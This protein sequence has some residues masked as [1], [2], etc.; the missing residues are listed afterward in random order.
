MT[1]VNRSL[2]VGVLV[3]MVSFEGVEAKNAADTETRALT[4]E[5]IYSPDKE[6]RLDFSGSVPSIRWI[7]DES[8]VERRGPKDDDE[9]D[10]VLVKVDAESGRAEPFFDHAKMVEQLA[11]LPG[12]DED[13]AKK[14]AYG[15]L[16]LDENNRRAL[17]NQAHDLFLYD[18]ET[19]E[20]RRLTFD[21]KEEVGEEF[22]PDG[23]FVSFI[24]DYNLHLLDLESGRERALTDGG[25]PDLFFGRLDWVYQEEVYGRGNFKG[26]WWSPDSGHLA[27]FK[28]DESKVREFTVVDHLPT[29]LTTEV[30]NYPKAGS[31]NPEV[32]LGVVSALGGDT[33]WLD[34][35]KYESIQHL[36]V[37]VGWTPDS[38]KVIF[39]VQ[40][41]EQEWLELLSASPATG[42]STKILREESP[43]FVNAL[44]MPEWLDDGG[45]LWRSERTGF[46][47]VYRYDTDYQLV[48]AVTEGEWEVRSLHGVDEDAGLVFVTAMEES[49]IAPHVYQVGLDGKGLKRLSKQS[50]S[51]SAS[52]SKKQT[53]F[54]DRW[55]N[56]TTPTQAR[57]YRRNGKQVRVVDENKVEALDLFEWGPVERHQ[58]KTR[59][60]FVME[61]MLMK[62][63]DFDPSK[64]YPVL[65]YNYGG[66]HAPVVRDAWGGQ[67]YAWH[68]MLAQKGYLIWMC[69]NR[70]ASG[71]GIKPTW[72]AFHRMGQPELADIEDGLRW[73]MEK[74]WVDGGR[75]GIWGW[76]YGGFMASYALTHSKMF[77]AGIAGAPVT[78]WHLY[79]SIYTER[80][81]GTPQ[82]NPEGYDATSV[83]KAAKDL[84]GELL[85]VHGTIDDNVHFQNTVQLV[86]ELQKAGKA[87]ELMIYPK[88][89]HG[90]RD[91][92]Q[93]FHLQR[94]MTDFLLRKL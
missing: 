19:E 13:T 59:D 61:A 60:G 18:L 82:N 92:D 23:R 41:R 28:L 54:Y 88:S 15:S 36:I 80:Y 86:Y 22:S 6:K 81:M 10:K 46:Q 1:F 24:R 47:H 31:P 66:P 72:E 30:T 83:T 89:R 64:K 68:Q 84:S 73:L 16:N 44:G 27:F 49:P 52:W 65:Q 12:M 78:D 26:Y 93:V 3:A 94:T 43:A 14:I 75:L 51:H 77:K 29:E 69:D 62:P 55:S 71:K 34:T 85:I 5:D 76:S 40:D 70:S 37:K 42:K 45:F 35:S 79:D 48:G 50:G 74:P 7:D 91:K 25:G 33:V 4:L 87:F 9:A 38:E 63:A 2:A 39:Q 11:A 21:P 56:V 90:V 17:I 8:W 58:V 53:Y 32:K 57:L 20:A 67:R